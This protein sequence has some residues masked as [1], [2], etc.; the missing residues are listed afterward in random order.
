MEYVYA[1]LMLHKIGR[2]IT[3]NNV[4]KIIEA[5]GGAVNEAKLKSV[6]IALEGVD[7][8][9]LI[10]ESKAMPVVAAPAGVEKKAEEKREEKKE[11]KREAA[12]GLGALFG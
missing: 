2:E 9:K 10:E 5:A 6:I 8:E 3:E 1:C 4:K 11:E 12:A 7:I